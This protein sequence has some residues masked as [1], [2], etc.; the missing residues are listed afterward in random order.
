MSQVYKLITMITVFKKLDDFLKGHNSRRHHNSLKQSLF[1]S[2]FEQ[3][4]E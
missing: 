4:F 2:S 1:P 3:Q